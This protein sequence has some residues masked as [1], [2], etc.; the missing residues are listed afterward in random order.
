MKKHTTRQYELFMR[1]RGFAAEHQGLFPAGSVG[2]D[3][4]S[5]LEAVVT[6]VTGQE[7]ARVGATG[8]AVNSRAE[9][10]AALERTLNK[11]RQTASLLA[12][13]NPLAGDSFQGRIPRLNDRALLQ[14]ARTYAADAAPLSAGFIQHGMPATFMVDLQSEIEA[15]ANA[16][17]RRQQGRATIGEAHNRIRAAIGRGQLAARRLDAYLA[18]TLEHD[19]PLLAAWKGIRRIGPSA[20]SRKLESTAEAAPEPSNVMREGEAA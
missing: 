17:D 6:E 18:N 15:F 19:D 3:A 1:L 8:E 4:L 9:A 13:E 12:A 2:A 20:R 7:V 5:E 11:V 10:R 14:A 16:L